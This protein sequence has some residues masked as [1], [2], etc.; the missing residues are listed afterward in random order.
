[1]HGSSSDSLARLTEQVVAAVDG[2]SDGAELGTGLFAASGVLAEQPSLRRAMTDPS[3]EAAGRSGLAEAVFGKHVSEAAASVVSEAAALRWVSSNDLG[4]ALEQLGVVAIVRAA[5]RDG[6]GDRVEA[7]LFEF[8]RTVT[9]SHELRSALSDPGRSVADK[10]AL[11]HALLDGKAHPGTVMLVEQAASGR[12]LTV[13]NAID[14]FVD[15]AARSR[16]RVVALVR[17]AQPLAA[18]EEKRLAAALSAQYDR[19][20][21][22]N[23]VVDP[24][25]IGGVHITVGDE[26]VDGSVSSRLAEA[27]RRLAG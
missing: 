21:H 22:L 23:T 8:G 5:D 1:M 2:G 27:G 15:L 19:T 4:A 14:T 24:A 25:V 12:H 17:V 18:D 20:V 3:T 26:V 6:A 16:D 9:E 10:Q 11:V 13:T 7:E